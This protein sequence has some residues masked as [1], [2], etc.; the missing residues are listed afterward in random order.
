MALLPLSF[1]ER[2][3]AYVLLLVDNYKYKY[4]VERA[5]ER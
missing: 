4:V 1:H 3:S 5:K 2:Y